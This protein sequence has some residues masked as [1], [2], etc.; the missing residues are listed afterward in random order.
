MSSEDLDKFIGALGITGINGYEASVNH[1]IGLCKDARSDLNLLETCAL[2]N[3]NTYV[4][5]QRH[6]LIFAASFGNASWFKCLFYSTDFK[7]IETLRGEHNYTL[8]HFVSDLPYE[9]AKK[10]IQDRIEIFNLI[11]RTKLD[12][13]EIDTLN[14][15]PP[16]FLAAKNN[17]GELMLEYF[18]Y[19]P[20]KLD[21]LR[22]YIHQKIIH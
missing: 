17:M 15:C 13:N 14:H 7:T 22:I 5:K 11:N 12:I 9:K 1:T 19:Y 4:H 2:V 3:T 10:R 21:I 8:F 16:I 18:K 6:R 20:T